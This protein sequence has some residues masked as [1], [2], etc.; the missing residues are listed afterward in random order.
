MLI[1]GGIGTGLVVGWLAGRLLDRARWSVRVLLLLGLS[2]QAALV[3]QL[4][5]L[6]ATLWFVATALLS[7]VICVAWVRAL[8]R[9]RTAWPLS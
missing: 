3:L 6:P 9:R 1:A 7:A 2:A 5:S 8:E 4:E